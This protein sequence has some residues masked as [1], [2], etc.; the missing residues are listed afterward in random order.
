MQIIV[1][2]KDENIAD[3]IVWFLKSFSDKGVKIREK[4]QEKK[5]INHHIISSSEVNEAYVKENWRELA[6]QTRSVDVNDD[7]MLE[8]A[9]WENHIAK[10]S[11]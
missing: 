9:H 2:I 11:N 4:E 5:N 6:L 8:E 3:K 1:D 7:V 10:H